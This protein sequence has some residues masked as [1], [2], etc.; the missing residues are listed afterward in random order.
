[1]KLNGGIL[2]LPQNACIDIIVDEKLY[3]RQLYVMGHEAQRRMMASKTVLVGC[4]GLGAE[5]AKN[6]IL[7]GIHSLVIVDP[8]PAT[9][10]DVGGNFY[11]KPEDVGTEGNGISRADICRPLLAELNP[12]VNVSVASDVTALTAEQLIPLLDTGITCLVVTIPLSKE[13]LIALNEKCRSVN[14]SFVYSLSCGAF[15]QVFCDFGPSFV[16]SDKDGN[17]PSASQIESVVQEDSKVVVKVLEDQ[18]RHGLETGDMVIFARLKGLPGLETNKN[19]EVNVT[20]PYT[21]EIDGEA[22]KDV[23]IVGEAQQ[24]YITQVKQPVN[25]AFE[26]YEKRLADL[27][28]CMMSD[29]A[30]FDRPTLLHKAFQA[31]GE[32]RSGNGGEYP[33]PG[34]VDACKKVLD[35]VSAAVEKAGED[36]LTPAQARIVLH[37][38]SGAKAILSPMCAAL[39]GIV[40]Q[41][42]LKAC[43]AKFSPING[44]FF[45][46]ADETLPDE[47]LAV[48]EVAP[49]NNGTRYDSQIAC[50]GK[51]I[52]QNL[53]DLNYFIVGAGAIGCEMLKNWALMVSNFKLFWGKK[54]NIASFFA[55]SDNENCFLPLFETGCWM[56]T[57]GT[58]YRNRHGSH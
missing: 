23:T 17:P 10:Y 21:F 49:Q 25:I 55:I 13:L 5:V 40:G 42:V 46:D 44:F 8:L 50:Y 56:R 9:T 47:L 20:G 29:F 34:D 1:M 3:S 35:I 2:Y 22:G 18:G 51:E 39:G 36:P 31:L 16:C 33:T 6:C 45:L 32:Y 48:D 7:A 11:L 38:A 12:Y 24:G 43:S 19:Y 57:Q 37:L 27:G 53:L 15:G 28:E 52:Q 41:E 58:Y 54:M 30:K 26:T 14:V 4:S